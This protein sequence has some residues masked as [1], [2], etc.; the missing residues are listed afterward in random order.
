MDFGGI[1]KEISLDGFEV[2]KKKCFCRTYSP[3]M[4][5]YNTAVA[6]NT[7]CIAALNNCEA[8]HI[9]VNERKRSIVVTCIS[10]SDPDAIVWNRN[11]KGEY[12]RLECSPFMKSIYEAW[13][14]KPEYKYRA[15]GRILQ[16]DGKVLL[17]FD[18]SS[19]EVWKGK[20]RLNEK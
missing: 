6:F 15:D 16:A 8:V 4:T 12:A 9:L 14:L 11:K 19:P 18:F 5:L 10:S 7:P 2:V 3:F 1:I 20:R 13:N 17:F